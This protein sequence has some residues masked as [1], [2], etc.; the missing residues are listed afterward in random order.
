VKR[1]FNKKKNKN[2]NK[3]KIKNIIKIKIFNYKKK[4]SYLFF[5]Y[6]AKKILPLLKKYKL[7]SIKLFFFIIN[8]YN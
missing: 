7:I 5:K 1:L 6:C 4:K 3:I 2:K 8:Y